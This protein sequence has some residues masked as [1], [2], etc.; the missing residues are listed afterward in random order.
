MDEELL[1]LGRASKHIDALDD[2]RAQARVATYLMMRYTAAGEQNLPS[3]ERRK[4]MLFPPQETEVEV[5][6]PRQMELP[7][8]TP[9][10]APTRPATPAATV[11]AT[12]P[13]D[14]SATGTATPATATEPGTATATPATPPAT[15]ATPPAPTVTMPKKGKAKPPPEPD[16][17]PEEDEVEVEI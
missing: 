10:P 8:T 13:P 12:T 2:P 5:A 17:E 3:D 16:P 9:V 6:D 7:G 11:A 1:A 15:P 14:T 4:Y